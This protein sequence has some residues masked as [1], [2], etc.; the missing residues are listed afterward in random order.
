MSGAPKPEAEHNPI[1]M[2]DEMVDAGA[3]ELRDYVAADVGPELMREIAAA[4]Y[5]AMKAKAPAYRPRN[6]F[7]K[8]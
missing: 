2:T 6:F 4:V 3:V 5:E 7:E 1:E 8:G